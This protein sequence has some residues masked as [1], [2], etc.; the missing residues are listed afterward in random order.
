MRGHQ[1]I[2]TADPCGKKQAGF[3]KA[4]ETFY[5]GMIVQVDPTVALISGRHTYKIYNRAVDGDQ[6]LGSFW[7]VTDEY[8]TYE[9]K[10]ITDSTTFDSYAA[11]LLCSLYSPLAGE[12]INLLFKNVTGTADDIIA[13]D[14][15][16]VDDDT[17][18][19]I[20]T[21]GTPETEVAAALEA[22]TDP[23]ADTQLWCQWSGH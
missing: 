17:G 19:V 23:T 7:V 11:G 12:E 16:M 6:P 14:I 10:G 5:P 1:T 13:G 3:V 21:T 15:V 18:K 9:G 2:V 4:G 20:A 8:L 22:I